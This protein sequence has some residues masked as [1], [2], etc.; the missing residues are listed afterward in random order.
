MKI[1][2]I[3]AGVSGLTCAKVLTEQGLE[4]EVFE[5]S[6]GVGGRVRTDER[7][8]FLLDRGFQVLFTAYPLVR[9]H[10]DLRGLEL[11]VFDPGAI[12]CRGREKSVLADP[13]R[14][15]VSFLPS[16]LSTA[17]TL[18]DKLSTLGLAARELRGGA[19]AA[20]EEDGGLDTTTR[21]YLRRLGFSERYIG[22]FFRP[23]YG[24]I[25]L[26]RSLST[27]ARVFRFTF[28]MLAAGRA[29][30]PAR[31][32]G[33]IPQQLA[34]R[35]PE[36]TIHLMS[37]VEG[38]LEDGGRIRGVRV[39]GRER[40][41]DAV[42]LATDAPAAGR[43]VGVKVPGGAVGEVCVYY[44]TNGLGAGKKIL[45]NASE[46]AFI[47]NAA[48]MSKVS[49]EYA[50]R[51]RHLLS[52]VAPGVHDGLSDEEIYRRGIEEISRW[53]PEARLEP[54]TLYRIPYCQFAQPPG[55]RTAL[56]K[57]RTRTPGLFLAGEYTVDSSINGA[58]L[59]GERAAREVL[60]G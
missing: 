5:A 36:G 42:V 20:G 30:V 44:A 33:R 45:L 2:V 34:A 57:T 24:G 18:R 55:F 4:V 23:F 25:F 49:E 43:L 46:G 14:D 8:G 19:V 16:A 58:M 56:P 50:P 31:G 38:L 22:S 9:R 6:D 17:A 35:L 51:G 29:A 12:I 11:R 52:A 41:A 15:P 1:F 26:D 40:E 53:F 3:G 39:N 48:E 47:N 60:A 21:E 27:S 37:P 7:E 13:F 32:M 59:A 10:L 54:L 28:R